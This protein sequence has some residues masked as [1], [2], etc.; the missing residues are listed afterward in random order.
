MQIKDFNRLYGKLTQY[1]WLPIVFT[2]HSTYYIDFLGI[3]E[4]FKVKNLH[5]MY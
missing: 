1:V 3:V 2:R 5:K 4:K